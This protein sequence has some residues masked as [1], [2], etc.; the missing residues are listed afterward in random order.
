MAVLLFDVVEVGFEGVD[1]DEV[2]GV[3]AVENH[4]HEADDIGERFLFLAEEGSLLEG[5][6]FGD[7]EVGLAAQELEGLA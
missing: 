4:V 7:G 6:G 3:D 2:G 1:V 5:L